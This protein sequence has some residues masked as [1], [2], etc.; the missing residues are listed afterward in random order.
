[1]KIQLVHNPVTGVLVS[2]GT[3]RAL[4]CFCHHLPSRS[5]KFF[6]IEN[7]LCARCFGLLVGFIVGFIT[8]LFYQ[9]PFLIS[10]LF[11]L[12]LVIDGFVQAILN[13][14]STNSRRFITGF[15]FGIGMFPFIYECTAF[16][17]GL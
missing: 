17:K 12:P 9:I 5:I 14:E 4:F 10:T 2:I 13:H 1:M 3:K 7:Y 6:G 15:L 8:L 16:L 11:L